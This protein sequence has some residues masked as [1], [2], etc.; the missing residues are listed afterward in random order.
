MASPRSIGNL[1][2]DEYVARLRRIT[3]ENGFSSDAGK[4]V[5]RGWGAMSYYATQETN[6]PFCGISPGRIQVAR[7]GDKDLRL[8][9][10]LEAVAIAKAGS[11]LSDNLMD[12]G[13]DMLSVLHDR[14]GGERLD[15]LAIKNEIDDLVFNIPSDATPFGW[16]S[17]LIQTEFIH[18][19]GGHHG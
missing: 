4:Q 12:L 10:Q 6:Y 13:L 8:S 7:R 1:I 2:A 5:K 18:K 14:Q 17:V 11:E 15:G 9:L 19:I 3:L 16:V